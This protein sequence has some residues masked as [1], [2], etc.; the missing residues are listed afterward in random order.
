M[1]ID[2]SKEQFKEM[3]LAAMLYSF[4][5]GG[6]ADD[7][8]E[9]FKKYE[10]LE[11]YLLKIAEENGFNDLVE[12][13]HGH[14]IP[15]DELSELEEEIMSEYDEDAFWHELMT[16]LGRRD[17]FRTVTPD[18]DKEMEKRDWLPD[19]AQEFFDRYNKE[20]E[21]YGVER[22]EIKEN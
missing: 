8:G 9:D 15:S 10:E 5:R 21:D 3:I 14:L 11:N 19:R 20:F 2:L 7:K 12:K 1:Q 16:R 17:F 13:F 6:L 18:E 4:I 22:L